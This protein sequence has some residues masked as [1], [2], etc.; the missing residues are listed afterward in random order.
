M[1]CRQQTLLAIAALTIVGVIAAVLAPYIYAEYHFNLR[2]QAPT[3]QSKPDVPVVGRWFD[4]YFIV[5][6]IDPNTFAIGEPR[7]DQG[8]YSYLI[9]GERRAVLFDAGSGLRDIVPVVRSLT[10]L[11]GTAIASHLHFDHVGALRSLQ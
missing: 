5:E 4:E 1:T 7:Y 3:V 6:T 2:G 11:P 9:I 10:S 8:N